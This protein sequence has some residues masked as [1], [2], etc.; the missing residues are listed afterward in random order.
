M[1]A[2]AVS[3]RDVLWSWGPEAVILA[4]AA[5]LRLGWPGLTEFKLDEAT[6]ISAAQAM[7]RGHN[8]P[9]AGPATSQGLTNGPWS[10]YFLAIP[11]L[12]SPDP[13][14]AILF[15]GAL[16]LLAVLGTYLLARRWLGQHAARVAGLLYATSPWAIF[17]TRK[18]WVQALMPPFIALYAGAAFAF[19]TGSRRALA[20]HLVALALLLQNYPATLAL[21]PATLILLAVMWRQI[22]WRVLPVSIAAS[23]LIFLPYVLGQI[24]RGWPDVQVALHLV[25]GSATVDTQALELAWMIAVGSNLHSLAGAE[26]FHDYLATVPDITGLLALEG[27]LIIMG[28]GWLFWRVLRSPVNAAAPGRVTALFLLVWALVPVLLLTCHTI[29]VYLHYFLVLLPAPY[30]MAGLAVQALWRRVSAQSASQAWRRFISPAIPTAITAI[31]ISQVVLVL[32]MFRFV[33][34]QHTSA[35]GLPLAYRLETAR[36]VRELAASAQMTEVIVISEEDNPAW[37]ETPSVFDALLGDIPRRLYIN[38]LTTDH[39]LLPANPAAV[40]IAP[41]EWPVERLLTTWADVTPVADVPLRPGEGRYRILSALPYTDAIHSLNP[42]VRLS[43]GVELFG[44]GFR[45]EL[46]PGGELHLALLWRITTVENVEKGKYHF[47]NHLV[48]AGGERWGQKDGPSVPPWNW[49]P[50]GPFLSAFAI[51]LA[52]DLPPGH[53]WLRTGMYRYPEIENIPILNAAGQPA[54]DAVLLGPIDV[55]SAAP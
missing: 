11:S 37:H 6:L 20:V 52:P 14:A 50:S 38:G 48:D 2:A 34:G 32:A 22:S 45:G 29:P 1:R 25:Q 40:L 51:S 8:L 49:R 46:Q 27:L 21:L 33:A 5:V 18:L 12:I 36:R 7:A 9:L 10:I 35:F 44:Y 43:N 39:A 15:V 55:I 13:L 24:Q 54:G 47:F 16:N 30:L 17:L 19:A 23:A 53:Y 4:L 41:G 42:P 3:W 28:A 31:A 26:T